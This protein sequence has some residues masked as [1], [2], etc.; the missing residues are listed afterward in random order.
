MLDDPIVEE[1]RKVRTAH[2]KKFNY[3]LNAIANDLKKQQAVG[4]RTSVVFEPRKPQPMVIHQRAE[5]VVAEKKSN[6]KP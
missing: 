5:P 2:A 4:K 3:D 6:Y 1:A